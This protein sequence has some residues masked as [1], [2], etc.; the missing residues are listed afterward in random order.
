MVF[1]GL[2]ASQ[3][4]YSERDAGDRHDDGGAEEEWNCEPLMVREFYAAE[5]DDQEGRGRQRAYRKAGRHL[6]EQRSLGELHFRYAKLAADLGDDR[7]DAEVKRVRIEEQAKRH[8][9]HA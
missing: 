2:L 1:I 7:Q 5:T 8:G 3:R 6:A 9:K 4:E